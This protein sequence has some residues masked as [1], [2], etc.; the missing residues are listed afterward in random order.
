MEAKQAGVLE[1]IMLNSEGYVVE[2]T[3]DNIF[4]VSDGKILT[5]PVHL[6]ALD[7][8]T[9]NFIIELAIKNEIELNEALLTKY[10]LYTADECFLTGTGAEIIPVVK[11]DGRPID[12]GKPGNITK[13][14][15]EEFSRS[16]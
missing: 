14:L 12:N 8:I 3:A 2:C 11:I 1:C 9:K 13:F 10:D 7:G 15:I 5:P 4:I 6:G 16:I